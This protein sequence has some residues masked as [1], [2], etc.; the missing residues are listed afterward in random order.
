M[1]DMYDLECFLLIS[2]KMS[3]SEAAYDASISQSALSKRIK[4]IEDILG[5]A[6]FNRSSTGVSL[7]KAGEIFYFFAADTIENYYKV[8]R[9]VSLSQPRSSMYLGCM[10]HLGKEGLT[11]IISNFASNNPDIKMCLVEGNTKKTLARL[12]ANEID[13]CFVVH[14]TSEANSYSNISKHYQ[15]NYQF[16]SVLDDIFC[17]IMSK[18]HELSCR[19]SLTFEEI[20]D[21]T[22]VLLD[23]SYSL[24]E[25]IRNTLAL[26][27]VKPKILYES[28]QVQTLM[29]FVLDNTAMTILSVNHMDAGMLRK[30]AC[31]PIEPSIRRSIE[32]VTPKTDD[33]SEACALFVEHVRRST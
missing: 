11:T 10:E 31:I 3:F 23:H 1:I 28:K 27:D 24:N 25:I 14:I 33:M 5:N 18:D 8:K 22:L 6:L 30:V 17:L 19:E 32:L 29:G 4:K 12:D 9:S 13:L 16:I 15:E 26:Y 20:K 2:E 7:T 21:Q